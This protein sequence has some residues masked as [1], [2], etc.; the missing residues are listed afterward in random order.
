MKREQSKIPQS[1]SFN[2]QLCDIDIIKYN[3]SPE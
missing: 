1:E 2:L 3:Y